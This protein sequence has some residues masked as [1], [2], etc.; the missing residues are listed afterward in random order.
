MSTKTTFEQFI[1]NYIQK[2]ERSGSADGYRGW[3]LANGIDSERLYRDAIKDISGDFSRAK[4]EYGTRA[5]RLSDLGL[6]ASGYSDYLNGKAYSEMQKRKQDAKSAYA[7]NELK[8]IKGYQSYLKEKEAESKKLYDTVVSE[9][10]EAKIIS[11]DDAYEYAI[12]AGLGEEAAASAAKKASDAAHKNVRLEVFDTIIKRNFEDSQAREYALAMGLS[13]YE[14][15]EL[16][17]YAFKINQAVYYSDDY[18][19]YLEE[20]RNNKK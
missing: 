2:K 9:I 12:G 15:D 7:D 20:K 11:Y 19:K 14:A 4:S 13:E 3:A 10:T 18:L 1:E 8:N 6:S 16:A 17:E 5:E